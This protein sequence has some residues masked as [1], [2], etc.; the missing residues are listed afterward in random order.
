MLN[1][2]TKV[3]L[4][5]LI[6]VL[7]GCFFST[8]EST[9]NPFSYIY[10]SNSTNI[11]NDITL[12]ST[13][14]NPDDSND[15]YN[16]N[17]TSNNTSVITNDGKVTRP[18]EHTEVTLTACTEISGSNECYDY[19]VF[20]IKYMSELEEAAYSFE[21]DVEPEIY[22]HI[23][24]P[25][26]FTYDGKLCDITWTSSHT[27]II[28]SSG[29]Y[30]MPSVDTIVT[31]TANIYDETDSESFNKTFT[32][33][34]KAEKSS[35][36][37]YLTDLLFSQYIEGSGHNNKAFEIYNGTG[38]TL[39]LSEYS[40]NIYMNDDE[41]AVE[42]LLSGYIAHNEYILFAYNFEESGMGTYSNT[43]IDIN[44]QFNGNDEIELLKNGI[45]LDS[46]GYTADRFS[47]DN[48]FGTDVTL[49]RNT[50]VT[51]PNSEY[52]T[53]EWTSYSK[54][55]FDYLENVTFGNPTEADVDIID[56]TI[57]LNSQS[58]LNLVQFYKDVD[59]SSFFSV[60]DNVDTISLD[61]SD[62]Y[63]SNTI[64]SSLLQTFSVTVIASDLS[65][66]ISAIKETFTVY[67][68]VSYLTPEII[69]YYSNVIN[70][71]GDT[72]RDAIA[73]LISN[74]VEYDYTSSSNT[75]V[76][77]LLKILDEDPNNA[78]NVIMFY[79][80]LSLSKECQDT[81]Y[82]PDH[83]ESVEWNREHV[84]SKSRGDFGETKGAG[85]DLH[86]LYAEERNMNSTKNNRYFTDCSVSTATNVVDRGYGNYTCNGWHFEPR[87]EI[88]GDVARILFYMAVRYN[89]ID[90]EPNL[91][92]VND[93]WSYVSEEQNNKLGVYGD[94]DVLLQWHVNDPVSEREAIRNNLV[95]QYQG[96]RNPFID[97]PEF[98]HL[99]F[100]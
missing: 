23:T 83:C 2:I 43:I 80:D 10:I 72:L 67:A 98:A 24:L 6:F 29:I 58:H 16:I 26:E 62:I 17:W 90:D 32:F 22:N 60:I 3:S 11:R 81:T 15:K 96:N 78:D 30:T 36:D 33:V 19:K 5:S 76:W 21:L 86:H 13:V 56:P 88:K 79:S 70:L 93:V 38:Q 48:S 51:S 89:G 1:K 91:D 68:E 84:W 66:N 9:F 94:L 74:H 18:L 82:P 47:G 27:N 77:D 41:A 75:D 71:T 35:T 73:A 55:T 20:V 85:T 63:I 99:I 12:Q 31:L 54:D 8:E 44:S 59:F 57:V 46:I 64:D 95:Y 87:D 50:N 92:L 28:S 53:S 69:E 45:S 61:S 25:L 100:S 39:D 49:V 97:Y 7:S 42:M 37:G 34:A 52:D 40:I 4:I 14:T 65:G